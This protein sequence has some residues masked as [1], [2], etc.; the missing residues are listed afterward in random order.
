M[1]TKT[2][3]IAGMAVGIALVF[4]FIQGA[5]RDAE[6]RSRLNRPAAPYDSAPPGA[7]VKH[8]PALARSRQEMSESNPPQP[9]TTL[10][11]KPVGHDPVN[12]PKVNAPNPTNAPAKKPLKDALAREALALVGDDPEAEAYWY[13]AINNPDLSPQERQDLIEDLNEDGFP[14]PK[15]PTPDDLPRILSRLQLIEAI[16]LDAM[17]KVNWDAFQEAYKDLLNLAELALGG[18]KPVH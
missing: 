4:A 5:K 13:G 11:P 9:E 7:I 16:A 1:K 3:V 14:D 12:P 10:T 2:L 15:H 6:Q 8:E 17:D 18:G